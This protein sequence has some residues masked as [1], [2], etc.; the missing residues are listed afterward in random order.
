MFFI[1]D[2]SAH[3]A[4]EAPAPPKRRP[5]AQLAR[6]AAWGVSHGAYRARLAA[7]VAPKNA[8]ATQEPWE[9]VPFI[10]CVRLFLRVGRREALLCGGGSLADLL[11]DAL[12]LFVV[13]SCDDHHEE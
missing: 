9:S 6:G 10:V 8:N 3:P 2:A 12:G 4:A 7:G 1:N 11:G 5:G 13:D